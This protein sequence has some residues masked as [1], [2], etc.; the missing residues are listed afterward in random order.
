MSGERRRPVGIDHGLRV[1]VVGSDHRHAT[2][3]SNRRDDRADS[4]IDRLDRAYGSREVAGVADHV[5]VGVVDDVDV[6]LVGLD[7]AHEL[8]GDFRRA[9]LGLQV[10]GRDLRA[11][12]EHASLARLRGLGAAVE[13]ERDV[14]VL[15]GLGDVELAQALLGED[16]GQDVSGEV[17]GVGD[18][19][20]NRRV[21]L[22]QADEMQ[23]R[24][25]RAIESLERVVGEGPRDL[26]RAVRSEVEEDQRVAVAEGRRE[27]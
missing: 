20:G 26:A 12:H 2:P 27:R 15:L 19:R 14:R 9:H 6:G 13:E 24:T 23:L 17:L 8:R 16:V 25:H 7:R 18:G 3:R 11:G 22:R 10:V 21:V 5:A 1:A 4:G